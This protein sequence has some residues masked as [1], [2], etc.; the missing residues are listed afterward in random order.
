VKIALILS[1]A[2]FVLAS[3]S[4]ASSADISSADETAIR[5]NVRAYVQA[6][7]RQDA[8]AIAALWSPKGIFVD[9]ENGRR[10]KGR[11]AIEAEFKQQF[12]KSGAE[13]LR[14]A[15]Q[16]IRAITPDVAIEDGTASVTDAAGAATESSYT[17]IHI[18]QDGMWLLDSV[19]ETSLPAPGA[20]R[21]HLQELDWLVGAWIDDGADDVVQSEYV[22]GVN[23]AFLIHRFTVFIGDAVAMQGTQIIG[24]DPAGK[25]IRS[26]AFDTEGGFAEATWKR[27]GERWIITNKSTLPDGKRG[28]AINVLRRI[29]ENRCSWKSTARQVD[30]EMLPNVDEVEIIRQQVS[31]SGEAAQSET[32]PATSADRE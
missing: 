12:R 8:K 24:W 26:W 23:Q 5:A 3:A 9:V 1:T 27:E 20:A 11:D 29:D 6:Y 4:K 31:Q 18:K 14:V 17:A 19:R 25:T 2:L 30:G 22:W 21:D 7:E 32:N 28:S 10:V 15:V 16:S 13:K